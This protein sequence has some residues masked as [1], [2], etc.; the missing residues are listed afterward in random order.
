MENE[1]RVTTSRLEGCVD[2]CHGTLTASLF[3]A[4]RS[5]HLSCKEEI[6]NFL[7]FQRMLKLGRIEEIVLY[8]ITRSID[9]YVFEGWN[10][11]KCLYLYIHWQRG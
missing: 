2:A 5:I 9:L 3:I 1:W 4:S 10:F 6:C 8:G 7:R 11:L